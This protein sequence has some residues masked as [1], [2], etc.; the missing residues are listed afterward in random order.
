VRLGVG[1]AW[2]EA[3]VRIGDQDLPKVSFNE[4]FYELKYSFDTSTT[5]TSRTG[6]EIGLTARKYDQSLDS[7]RITGSGCSTWTRPSAAGRTPWCWV[8]ATGA[9]W[10]MPKW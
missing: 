7:T 3:E 10:M 6:E 4:G 9:R 8:G 5:C 2:G 1:K